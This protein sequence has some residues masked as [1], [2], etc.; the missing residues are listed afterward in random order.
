MSNPLD[1][2]PGSE[3][4]SSYEA[5]FA[6]VQADISQK[7]DTIPDL[8]G[9]SKKAALRAAERAVDEAD[10][11]VRFSPSTGLLMYLHYIICSS[12]AVSL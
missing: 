4:F 8:S 11:I 12:F 10:E 2:A 7:L 3:L 1:S 9:E 6:V 5:D